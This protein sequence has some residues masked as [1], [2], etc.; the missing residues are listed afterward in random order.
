MGKKFIY[1]RVLLK[2]SGEA[3]KGKQEHGYNAEAVSTVVDRIKAAMDNKIQMAL[4][5]GAGNVWRGVNGKNWGMDRVSADYMG[6]LA[7]VMNALCLRDALNS[8]GVQAV[9]QTSIPM[10]PIAEPF[11]RLK[12]IK[13]LEKGRVVI[14]AG[15]T[16]SPYFTTDTTASLRAL[17]TNCEAVLKATKVDGIYTADPMK[18]PDAKRY[19]KLSFD[20]A[21]SKKLAVMDLTAFSMCSEN[22]LPIIVFNF[23]DPG[24][25]TKVLGGDLSIATVVE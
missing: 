11:D 1:K 14:F 20:E 15:G 7:T 13:H 12:A 8:K 16:G 10:S 6:M 22:K 5:V 4:V 9:V 2:I 17:E 24:S 19:E 21:I 3:L 18:N 25:L 23:S